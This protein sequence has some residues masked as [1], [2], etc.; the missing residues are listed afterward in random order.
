MDSE[1]F[2]VLVGDA[3]QTWFYIDENHTL[4]REEYDKIC[5]KIK[6]CQDCNEEMG[7][8]TKHNDPPNKTIDD[9]H[10]CI[11]YEPKK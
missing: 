11:H 8:C 10:K 2:W 1:T 6:I 7:Y 3:I 4:T 5:R 9:L